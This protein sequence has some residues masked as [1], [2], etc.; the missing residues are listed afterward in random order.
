MN[1]IKAQKFLTINAAAGEV[2]QINYE[3]AHTI[4]IIND[5]DGSIT[6]SDKEA[7]SDDGTFSNCIILPA[8]S[9]YN[10]LQLPF[11]SFFITAE[12]N[13]NISVVNVA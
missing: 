13:G 8:G 7:F 6:I 4:S 3:T 12:E 10:N 9:Y 2:Y 5:T 11:S 1:A